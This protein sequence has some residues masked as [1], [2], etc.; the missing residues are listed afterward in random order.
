MKGVIL[1]VGSPSTCFPVTCT[2]PLGDFSV[3]N[4]PLRQLQALRLEAAGIT[5]VGDPQGATV[6]LPISGW[7]APEVLRQ[8]A[9]SGGET[10]VR[11][12]DGIILAWKSTSRTVPPDAVTI[13]GGPESFSIRFP[14][15]LLRVHEQVLPE[16]FRT[17]DE[18]PETRVFADGRLKAG[19]NTKVL[20]GVYVE[21]DVVIGDECKIGPNCYLRGKTSIGDGCHIGQAV[22]VK[23][24]IIL[25]GTSL[26]H[27]S[28]CGDSI[29]CE[30][31]NFGAGTIVANL[32]HDGKD[33]R[34][35]VGDELVATGR[36]KFGT[37]VGDGVH[38]GIH[39]SIYPGR[40]LWPGLT[41]R[42]G[43]TV[44]HDLR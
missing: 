12:V 14:W 19:R 6:F 30:N 21:G 3:A 24:S 28:Y 18:G 44:R 37:V 16:L 41:T 25:S 13:S 17:G 42:P 29:L 38:T 9:D 31:V 35:Q 11:G 32:R 22:E 5:I 8:L 2:R 4:R 1:D 26:G 39:T 33:H 7:V 36:R 15:D 27:L 20:P 10:V 40:K 34:S 43:E 23:N